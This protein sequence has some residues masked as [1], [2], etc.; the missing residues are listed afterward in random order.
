MKTTNC[1]IVDDE[2]LAIK[3][4]K[5]HV[6]EIPSLNLIATCGNAIEAFEVLKKESIDLIFLD[7]QMPTM[8]GIDFVK[9]LQ[10]APSIIF[11][12]AYR[13]Y[14]VESYE[15]NVVDYLLKPITFTR[16]FQAVNKFLEQQETTTTVVT[17][18]EVDNSN[19][20]LYVNS[21]KKH[22]KVEFD[23]IKYIESIKDY[24]RIHSDGKNII[25][26]ERISDFEEKLP[27]HFLRVHRSFIINTK[28]ITA[29]TANDIEINEKEIPI[30]SSYK[31][32]VQD[33]LKS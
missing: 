3:L 7:I 29:F 32:L 33:R 13:D 28:K 6:D 21:N 11:T 31:K 15:L 19:D 20:H 12:T 23:Q 26:R 27:A 8:T 14:A 2:P 18:P 17:I 4:I 10:N 1:I 5:R 22:I 25:T 30:G 9:T 16:F 24:I